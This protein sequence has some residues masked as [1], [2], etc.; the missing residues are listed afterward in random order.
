LEEKIERERWGGNGDGG[1]DGGITEGEKG[2]EK[3]RESDRM[4]EE[5]GQE[6]GREEEGGLSA[7]SEQTFCKR[8]CLQSSIRHSHCVN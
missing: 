2:K 6:F 4:N 3:R 8:A 5:E 7:S 1:E